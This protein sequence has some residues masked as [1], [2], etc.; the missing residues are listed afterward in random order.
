MTSLKECFESGVA[1]IGMKNCMTLFQTA[2]SMSLE[3]NRRATAGEIAAR[4]ASQFGLKISPSNVGQAFSAMSIATTISRGKAKYV[5][6]PTELE[7]ILRVGKEECTEIS[8]KLE[9][10]LS[11]YQEIA[12]RVDGLINQLREALRLDGEERKLRAQIRQVRGE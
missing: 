2:Y 7:P 1:L 12:G 3:G 4:A 9:E 11:E 10:S 6:N 8:D 5:L